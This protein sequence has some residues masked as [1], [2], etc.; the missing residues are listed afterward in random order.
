MATK[1][2]LFILSTHTSIM[3]ISHNM[4]E[5]LGTYYYTPI[6]HVEKAYNICTIK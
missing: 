5:D 6:V 3:N 2:L 1:V 4:I